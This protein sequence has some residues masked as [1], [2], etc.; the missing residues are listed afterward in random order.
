MKNILFKILFPITLFTFIAN[1][2]EWKTRYLPAM[3]VK[4]EASK[5]VQEFLDNQKQDEVAKTVATK[6]DVLGRAKNNISVFQEQITASAQKI[7][8]RV[9]YLEPLAS[10]ASNTYACSDNNNG[11]TTFSL[12]GDILPENI[13]FERI[14]EIETKKYNEAGFIANLTANEIKSLL[15]G[16]RKVYIQEVTGNNSVVQAQANNLSSSTAIPYT[17]I[18]DTSKITTQAHANG[19]NGSGVSAYL[20]ENGCP[21]A[22]HINTSYLV[23]HQ[24]CSGITSSHATGMIQ[25]FQAAA[26][27]TILHEFSTSQNPANTSNSTNYDIGIYLTSYNTNDSLYLSYDSYLDNYIL[28]NNTIIFVLAN[29]QTNASGNFNV[30]SPGKALNAITV[31]AVTPFTNYYE[32]YSRWK[33]S[34][35]KNQKPE[36]ANYTNFYFPS[37]ASFVDDFGY[38]YNATQTGTS[39][40]TAYSAGMAATMLQQK[41]FYKKHPEAFKSLMIAISSKQIH[42]ARIFDS[43]NST[44]AATGLPIYPNFNSK[45][46]SCY[47]NGSNSSF[48]NSNN[49]ITFT[50]TGI[51]AGKRY[52]IALAWLVSGNYVSMLKTIPQD[53]D[54]QVIQNGNVIA[55]SVSSRNPFEV[56]DFIAE[57]SSNLT[58]KIERYANSGVGDVRLGYT[59]WRE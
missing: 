41:P 38:T 3:E 30:L 49:Q 16:E 28:S 26:P 22:S 44:V 15:Q 12:N 42:S 45:V 9:S 34:E 58:I 48:F 27:R 2:D 39:A 31:G 7:L 18:L 56:V 40:A 10:S 51:V 6:R 57:S 43:D 32:S 35:I 33:N 1:A 53:I 19:Y 47:W 29:N 24:N 46:R 50:E 17:S 59:L 11:V 37:A 52:R 4:S 23:Q 20:S 21:K 14:Q 5:N 36:I 13:F 8:V 54:L 25:V 55:S